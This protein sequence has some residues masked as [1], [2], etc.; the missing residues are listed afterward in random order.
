MPGTVSIR[1]F[2]TAREAA[3]TATIQ[4]PTGREGVLVR[5]VLQELVS[6]TPALAPILR[7]AR[8]ARNGTYLRGREGRLRPGDEFAVHP[9]YSGG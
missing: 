1:L 7:Q 9:P 8:F 6:Q 4:R 5:S 2:A 3:G